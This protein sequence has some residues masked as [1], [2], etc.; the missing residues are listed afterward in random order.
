MR[1]ET[2]KLISNG[3][4][5]YELDLECV[6]EEARKTGRKWQSLWSSHEERRQ[7]SKPYRG[8]KNRP[9]GKSYCPERD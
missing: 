3:N 9:A 1:R 2:E 5:I 4:A 8:F 6:R 7:S